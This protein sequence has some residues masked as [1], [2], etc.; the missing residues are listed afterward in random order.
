MKDNV[1]CA[2]AHAL[3]VGADASPPSRSTAE[4]AALRNSPPRSGEATPAEPADAAGPAVAVRGGVA[5]DTPSR[6]SSGP[7]GH[8]AA[9]SRG[10]QA[11]GGGGSS[12]TAG[13]ATL[14][15]ASDMGAS[16]DDDGGRRPRRVEPMPHGFPATRC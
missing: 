1:R 16:P 15:T 11:V 5:N 10:V 6:G 4:E 13:G 14:R 3:A 7:D 12:P 8:H 9:G 2:A